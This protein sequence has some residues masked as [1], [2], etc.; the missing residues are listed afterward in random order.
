MYMTYNQFLVAVGILSSQKHPDLHWGPIQPPIQW[1]PMVL[2][3]G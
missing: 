3:P 1:V 2:Y